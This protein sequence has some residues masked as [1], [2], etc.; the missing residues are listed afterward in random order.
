MFRECKQG[1]DVIR[2]GLSWYLS[3]D[4]RRVNTGVSE[5]VPVTRGRD[6]GVKRDEEESFCIPK[7]R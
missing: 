4:Y 1:S 7:R 6:A 3:T 2:L 5:A